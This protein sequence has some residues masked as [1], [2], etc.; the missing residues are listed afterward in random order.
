VVSRDHRGEPLGLA[1]VVGVSVRTPGPA[2]AGGSRSWFTPVVLMIGVVVACLLGGGAPA[3][4]TVEGSN[5]LQSITPADGASVP[6]PPTEIT[7]SFNQEVDDADD[8]AVQVGC[9][10]EPQQVGTETWDDDRLVATL[11]LVSVLPSGACNISWFLRNDAGETIANGLT[12]FSVLQDAAATTTAPAAGVTT[13]TSEFISVPAT[14]DSGS[15]VETET[16][17]NIGGALWFGRWISTIGILAV[18]GGL[19]LISVGWPEGPEYIVTVRFLRAAWLLGVAGTI[20]YVIA[21]TADSSNVSF[22]SAASPSSWLD[23]SDA[24]WEGRGALLRLVLVLATGWVASRP[25]RII[26]PTSAMWAWGIPGFALV[27]VAMSRVEGPLAIIGFLVGVAHVLAVAVWFGG[28][29]LVARVVLAGPGEEDLVHATRS[30]SRVSVPAML[31]AAITGVIQVIRLD[32]GDLF[33]SSHGRVLLLKVIVVAAM[34]AVSLAIRQQITQRLD[35]M[36][37]MTASLAERFRRAFHAEAAL[38][39]VVLAFS[40]WLLQLTPPSIDPF[41]NET[42]PIEI[43]INNNTAGLDARIFVGAGAAGPPGVR[44][45]VEAPS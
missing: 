10:N 31:V 1:T 34:L 24:G 42:Y 44:V 27:T 29:A 13:T 16:P 7:L 30:F 33:T 45:E 38:G 19:A 40:G 9:N 26:D 14:G 20:L 4:A 28:A 15:Q 23:L 37:E 11:P 32:G 8:L 36:H 6:V 5:S 18:F 25:E 39:V 21:F 2:D 41:A 22:G 3:A 17:G 43:P 35:R 12:T